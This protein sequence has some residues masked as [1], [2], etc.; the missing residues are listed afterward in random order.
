MPP[1]TVSAIVPAYNEAGR[2]GQ[3]LAVLTSYPGFTEV[4][5]VDD[6]STDA[7]ATVVAAYPVRYLRL[8]TN[9]GK[10]YAMDYA[11]G[12]ARGTIIFFCDADIRGL[13][14]ATVSTI[15]APVTAGQA[16]MSIAVRGRHVSLLT[17]VLAYIFPMTTLIGGE[18]AITRKLWNDL[19]AYYKHGFRI[20]AGLNFLAGHRQPGLVFTVFPELYQ[21]IKE[22]KYGLLSGFLG[23]VRMVREILWAQLKLRFDSRVQ[24]LTYHKHYINAQKQELP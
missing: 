16:E 3:V 18:R 11:V 10:G 14:L 17:K 4:I 19:P 2:L 15:L 9:H 7:T 8:P 13:T 6:G 24:V 1:L 23:R 5:V 22:K 12:Q 20:E 21:V